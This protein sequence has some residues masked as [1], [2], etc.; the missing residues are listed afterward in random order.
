M[1]PLDALGN[2]LRRELMR[3][4]HEAP[5]SVREL[6][7]AFPVSRPAISRHLQVLEDAGLV[8]ARAEGTRMVYALRYE[9]LVP[10]QRFI[11]SFWDESLANLKVLAEQ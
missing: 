1:D 7:D 11:A 3:R 10:V 2:P 9:G 8:Q 6:A 4:L 5:V